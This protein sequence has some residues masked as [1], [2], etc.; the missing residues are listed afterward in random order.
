MYTIRF[1]RYWEWQIWV[2][3]KDSNPL[4][5]LF[6]KDKKD[7]ESEEESEDGEKKK[8]AEEESEDGEKK[9]EAEEEEEKKEEKEEKEEEKEPTEKVNNFQMTIISNKQ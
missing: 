3:C 6:S 1:D 7:G 8:E 4:A 5:K 2:C 9:E